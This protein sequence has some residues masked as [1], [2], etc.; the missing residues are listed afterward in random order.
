[1]DRTLVVCR[2][3]KSAWTGGVDDFDR[4]LEPRGKRDAAA[5]GRWLA[6]HVGGLQH[7]LCSPA[8]RAQHTWELA[9]SEFGEVQTV[10]EQ[11]MYGATAGELIAI[12]NE[13]PDAVTKAAVIGHN[14]GLEDLVS[15]L[16]GR[17]HRLKTS[18]IAVLTGTGDWAT[19]EPGWASLRA[20]AK[21]RG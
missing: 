3:S 8:L 18:E 10:H 17:P 13:L 16:I 20:T 4:P 21:P 14:P 15:V 2:H 19:V 5:A 7:A 12:I 1:M 6:E 11:R 9:T